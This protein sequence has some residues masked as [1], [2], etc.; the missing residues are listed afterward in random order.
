[1]KFFGN[2]LLA[3]MASLLAGPATRRRPLMVDNE[4]RPFMPEPFHPVINRPVERAVTPDMEKRFDQH[5][6]K[7]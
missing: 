2:L 3:G 7:A 4:F 1:M 5:R 6:R